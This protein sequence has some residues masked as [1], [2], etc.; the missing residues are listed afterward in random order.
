VEIEGGVDEEV[1]L[2]VGL[3]FGLDFGSV[4]VVMMSL[5]WALWRDSGMAVAVAVELL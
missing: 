5:E 1:E 3:E 2:E 4:A